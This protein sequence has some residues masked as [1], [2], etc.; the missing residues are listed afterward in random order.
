MLATLAM[1]FPAALGLKAPVF[2]HPGFVATTQENMNGIY[3]FSTTPD[4]PGPPGK[5]PKHFSDYPGGVEAFD[6]YSPP[7]STLYSQVWWRALAP[8]SLPDDI[9]ARYNGSG[10]AIVGYEIDQV[11][12]TPEGDV[13]VPISATYNHHYVAHM[14]GAGAR[15][16]EVHL[17]GPDDPLA[18]EVRRQSGHGKIQYDQRHYLVEELRARPSGGG[19]GSGRRPVHQMFS[20]GN[21]GEY[22]KTFHGFAPGYALVVD[23][24][25]A[26]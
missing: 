1:A 13:S 12:R 14:V 19:R 21:G 8:T 3:P 7:M 20:S 2:D 4:A 25:T 10:M 18:A 6:V 9:I 11:R 26:F 16:R 22:R 24:P 17:T 15:F 23:S 5:M